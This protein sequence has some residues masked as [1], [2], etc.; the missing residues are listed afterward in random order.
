MILTTLFAF[1]TEMCS[2]RGASERIFFAL[3][4]I[5]VKQVAFLAAKC[6]RQSY[7]EIW[8]PG[9]HCVCVVKKWCVASG[10]VK[11]RRTM[12]KFYD[13]PHLWHLKVEFLGIKLFI[14]QIFAPD[15][16]WWQIKNVFNEIDFAGDQTNS[17]VT[18]WNLSVL[19]FSEVI[20]FFQFLKFFY[21]EN[22]I[23]IYCKILFRLMEEIIKEVSRLSRILI[24][25]GIASLLYFVM[26]TPLRFLF[27]KP[28]KPVKKSKWRRTTNLFDSLIELQSKINCF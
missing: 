28:Q 19:L 5:K 2:S 20:S 7:C 12:Y 22:S 17:F 15:R 10:I 26:I 8:L 9:D 11:V 25:F 13:I 4:A 23:S 16:A 3:P 1:T 21:S 27:G 24:L 18:L 14:S 6:R